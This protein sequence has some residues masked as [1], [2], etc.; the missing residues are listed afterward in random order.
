M[1]TQDRTKK[2]LSEQEVDR[3]VVAQ[4]DDD[5]AWEQPVRVHKAKP[6]SVP[7]PADLAARAAFLA[8]LHRR[9][10]VEEWLTRIIQERVE[11]EEAAFVGVKRDLAVRVG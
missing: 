5:P 1:S 6:A 4:A 2:P 7:I 3:I 11:L 8:Q 10:S 9:P